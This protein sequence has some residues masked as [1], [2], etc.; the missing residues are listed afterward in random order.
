MEFKNQ[1]EAIKELRSLASSCKQAI[2]IHG[3]SGCGKTYLAHMYHRFIH[4]N[5]FIQIGNTMQD[6]RDFIANAFDISER[7]TVCIENIDAGTD[8]V[9][10]AILKIL[11]EPPKNIYIVITARNVKKIPVTILSRCN[12]VYVSHFRFDDLMFYAKNQYGLKAE[13]MRDDIKVLCKNPNDIDFIMN[14]QQQDFEYLKNVASIINEKTPI[15]TASWKLQSFPSGSKIP[16]QM[17]IRSLYNSVP[18]DLKRIVIQY[19]SDIDSGIP[20]HVIISAIALNLK[21]G[22]YGW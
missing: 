22:M 11:E 3:E 9:S 20:N 5:Q 14:L 1:V 18:N 16:I 12:E 2:L 17:L 4:T 21:V 19:E 15:A 8:G 13:S 10:Q 7:T 6:I